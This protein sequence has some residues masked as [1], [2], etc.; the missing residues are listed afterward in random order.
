MTQ[1]H[2]LAS[3]P[4][5][6]W[7]LEWAPAAAGIPKYIQLRDA[8]LAS[9]EGGHFQPGAKLPTEQELARTTPFSLG[10]VQRA[11]NELVDHGVVVRQQGNG[12]FVAHSRKSM[13]LPWHCRFIADDGESFLPVYPQVVD[14]ERISQRGPWSTHLGQHGDNVLRI[15]R[16]LNIADEFSVFSCFYLNTERFPGIAEKPLQE[17]DGENLKLMISREFGLPVTHVEQTMRFEKFPHHIRT[18]LG[19]RQASGM[20]LEI[21]ASAGRGRAVYYQALYIPRNARRLVL[22]DTPAAR[23]PIPE[24]RNH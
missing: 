20:M 22:S 13:D 12:S 11:L 18:A 17:F 4:T 7:P 16:I 14:R 1:S 8:L 19:L 6:G 23:N 2:T 21:A 24:S 5:A 15:D 3:S 10:T 9:I